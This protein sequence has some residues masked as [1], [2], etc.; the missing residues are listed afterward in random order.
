M[1]RFSR[2]NHTKIFSDFGDDDTDDSDVEMA[3]SQKSRASSK[4]KSKASTLRSVNHITF[5]WYNCDLN[6]CYP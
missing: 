6:P 3:S 2:W 5:V 1:C 4:L